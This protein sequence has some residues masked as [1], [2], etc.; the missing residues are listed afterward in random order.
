MFAVRKHAV[1]F[2]DDFRMSNNPVRL[3]SGDGIPIAQTSNALDVN[4]ASGSSGLPTGAS[5]ATLQT[6][7]NASLASIDSHLGDVDEAVSTTGVNIKPSD[8]DIDSQNIKK[9]EKG[10]VLDAATL[11]LSAVDATT[12]GAEF[13]MRY[14]NYVAVLMTVAGAFNWTFKLQGA[15]ASGGSFVDMY[16]GANLCSVQFQNGSRVV[17]WPCGAPYAKIVATEDASGTTATVSAVPFNR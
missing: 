17:M 6:A 11:G 3:Q 4:I 13:D 12:N 8:A 15:I 9:M 14:H 1:P 16:D 5:T 10:A 7:G 2:G